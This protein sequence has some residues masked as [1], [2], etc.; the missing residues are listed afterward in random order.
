MR[1]YF[2]SPYQNLITLREGFKK[3][4][5]KN[6][7]KFHNRGG[8]AWTLERAENAKNSQK[9][10]WRCSMDGKMSQDQRL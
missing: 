8:G 5:L 1:D 4:N 6:Y 3:R 7:G 9:W 2:G 10:P